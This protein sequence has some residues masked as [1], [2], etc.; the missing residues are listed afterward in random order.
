MLVPQLTDEL[1]VRA[2]VNATRITPRFV[3]ALEKVACAE[4]DQS[5]MRDDTC[6]R[7]SRL[8]LRITHKNTGKQLR[9]PDN[10]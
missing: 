2:L 10:K 4:V 5:T 9:L 1:P 6:Q 8:Q 3:P 7:E